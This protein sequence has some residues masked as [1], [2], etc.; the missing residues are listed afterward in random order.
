MPRS[1]WGCSLVGETVCPAGLRD[2]ARYRQWHGPFL[3]TLCHRL[4]WTARFWPQQRR[5]YRLPP[6]AACGYPAA[7]VHTIAMSARQN[8]STLP[9]QSD[10]PAK[11]R[12]MPAATP[13]MGRNEHPPT[14]CRGAIAAQCAGLSTR[15]LAAR[16]NALQLHIGLSTTCPR[17][18]SRRLAGAWNPSDD[19]TCPG[20]SD[21]SKI[22]RARPKCGW[23][24]QVVGVP[25]EGSK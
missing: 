10:R 17:T 9:P 6:I 15:G 5:T 23:A 20:D 3:S 11:G 7:A 24:S 21:L 16:P 8:A 25:E 13:R 19:R 12:P 14:A 2:N 1:S 22:L 4:G 18:H